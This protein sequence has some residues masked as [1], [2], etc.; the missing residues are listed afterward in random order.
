M[1]TALKLFS[2]A[3]L[4]CACAA[5][6]ADLVKVDLYGE[7]HGGDGSVSYSFTFDPAAYHSYAPPI[8]DQDFVYAIQPFDIFGPQTVLGPRTVNTLDFFLG[9]DYMALYAG[10]ALRPDP[11]YTEL[12]LLQ[13]APGRCQN[14]PSEPLS[15]AAPAFVTKQCGTISSYQYPETTYPEDLFIY[16]A[17]FTVERSTVTPEPASGVLL[18]SGLLAAAGALWRKRRD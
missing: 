6:R 10:D 15:G 16:E 3:V 5:G 7:I 1:R 9:G 2:A 13:F 17:D 14:L 11:T 12:L 4:F 8:Y 18:S